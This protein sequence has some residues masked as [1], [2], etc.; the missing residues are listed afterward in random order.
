MFIKI[1][2]YFSSENDLVDEG[3]L[4]LTNLLIPGQLQNIQVTPSVSSQIGEN[5]VPYT[6]SFTT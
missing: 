2:S 4:P 3:T 5:N 6:V 1:K